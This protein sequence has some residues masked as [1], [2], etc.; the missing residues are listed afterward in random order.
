MKPVLYLGDDDASRAA[1]YLCG[2]LTWAEIPFGRVSGGES[3]PEDFD[4][5]QWSAIIVSDYASS[6]WRSGQMERVAEAVRNGTG[7]AMFGG[8][9]SFHGLKPDGEYNRTPIAD[10]LPVR[11]PETDDRRNFA[12]PCL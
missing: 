11:I 3:P 1:A 9:E 7:L 12:Q 8:W 2:V 10:A 5:T 4:P 6:F